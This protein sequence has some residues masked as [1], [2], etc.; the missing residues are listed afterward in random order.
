MIDRSG[1]DHYFAQGWQT[2]AHSCEKLQIGPV[3]VW[4]G[5][6]VPDS[7]LSPGTAPGQGHFSSPS[8]AS[9]R[10]VLLLRLALSF[11]GADWIAAQEPWNQG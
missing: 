7:C 4:Q 3:V 10:Q 5:Q 2:D 8:D 1:P 9:L 11:P 6:R